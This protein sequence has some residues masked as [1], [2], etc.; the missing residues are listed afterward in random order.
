MNTWFIS[1]EQQPQPRS[2]PEFGARPGASRS[3]TSFGARVGASYSR[4]SFLKIDYSGGI[5]P[6]EHESEVRTKIHGLLYPRFEGLHK[7][8]HSSLF[9][10][11][12][13]SS[14]SFMLFHDSCVP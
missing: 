6:R 3:R 7:A 8:L 11:H 13:W 2:P 4:T 5:D 14:L 9:T 12:N 10:L 1:L